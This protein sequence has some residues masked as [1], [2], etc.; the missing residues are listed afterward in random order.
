[1]AHGQHGLSDSDLVSPAAG[2]WLSYGRDYAETRFSPLDE[3]DVKNVDR[4]GLAWSWA[5]PAAQGRPESTP[6]VRDGVMYATGT[7]SVVFALDARTNLRDTFTRDDILTTAMLYWLPGRVLS[8]AR[9]CSESSNPVPGGT[10]GDSGRVEGATGYA[11]F[12]AEP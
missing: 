5:I 8:A 2:E 10:Q 9:I 11:R 1:M 6:L 7:W 12:P 4:L 3:I